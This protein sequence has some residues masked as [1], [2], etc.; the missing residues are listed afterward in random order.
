M[1]TDFQAVIELI[2]S[3]RFLFANLVPRLYPLDE[4]EEVFRTAA[5]KT[6]GAV[7][8]HVVHDASAKDLGG[9]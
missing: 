1:S 6:T 3:Q 8:E 7:K 9:V 2:T 5:D 4:I